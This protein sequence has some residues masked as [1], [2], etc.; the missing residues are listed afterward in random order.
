MRGIKS[1]DFLL[2]NEGGK[3]KRRRDKPRI[4]V[5]DFKHISLGN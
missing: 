1:T 4:T 2:Q 5:G 3:K